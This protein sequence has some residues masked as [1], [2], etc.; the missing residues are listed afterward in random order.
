VVYMRPRIRRDLLSHDFPLWR[1]SGPSV[2]VPINSASGT[3]SHD[4]F[5]HIADLGASHGHSLFSELSLDVPGTGNCHF[6]DEPTC[7]PTD[8][9][10]V[11]ERPTA[12]VGLPAGKYRCPSPSSQRPKTASSAIASASEARDKSARQKGFLKQGRKEHWHWGLCWG[13]HA[14][15]QNMAG[16]RV[17]GAPRAANEVPSCSTL[18]NALYQDLVDVIPLMESFLV[19]FLI[20]GEDYGRKMPWIKI[21]N[22]N[23]AEWGFWPCLHHIDVQTGGSIAVSF[24]VVSLKPLFSI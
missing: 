21:S 15:A 9:S 1:S 2:A 20:W 17:F 16:V 5:H 18:D 6:A 4:P 23:M 13:P 12:P 8:Q 24:Q 10:H 22:V 11:E 3:L 7:D 19:N 14:T